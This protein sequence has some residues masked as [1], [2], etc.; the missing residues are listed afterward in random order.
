MLKKGDKSN[1]YMK[2]FFSC[3]KTKESFAIKPRN[4]SIIM[5]I[6]LNS[7]NIQNQN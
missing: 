7:R 2:S 3:D 1:F 4:T 6:F 5:S